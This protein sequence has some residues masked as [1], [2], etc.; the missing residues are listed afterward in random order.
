[1]A[2]RPVAERWNHDTQEMDFVLSAEDFEKV[3]QG[4]GCSICLED[5]NGIWKPVCPTCDTES[6][7]GFELGDHDT[8]FRVSSVA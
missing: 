8:S 6:F 3:R 2:I 7:K 5:Y 1:M 4:Y